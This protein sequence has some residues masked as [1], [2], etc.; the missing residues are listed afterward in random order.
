MKIVSWFLVVMLAFVSISI[1]NSM[2]AEI[3]HLHKYIGKLETQITEDSFI[4]K[5]CVSSGVCEHDKNKVLDKI[6]AE[7]VELTKCPYGTECLGANCPSNTDCMICGDHVI[8]II[9]KYKAETEG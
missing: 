9:D 2:T 4:N 1:H 6:R 7:I 8:E 5:P 3:N